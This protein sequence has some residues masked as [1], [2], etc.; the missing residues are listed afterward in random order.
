MPPGWLAEWGR[1]LVTETLLLTQQRTERVQRITTALLESVQVIPPK[2][3]VVYTK[4]PY[5]STWQDELQEIIDAA[6]RQASGPVRRSPR[7]TEAA[8]AQWKAEAV[9]LMERVLHEAA[10]NPTPPTKEP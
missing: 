9:A 5:V 8:I 7:D 6:I 4:E 10:A 2:R 1:L 3:P